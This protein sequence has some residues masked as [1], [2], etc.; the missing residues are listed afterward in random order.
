MR[1]S[2]AT[3]VATALSACLF[4]SGCGSTTHSVRTVTVTQT[5]TSTAT[6]TVTKPPP[7]TVTIPPKRPAAHS[8]SYT[9]FEGAYFTV[10]YPDTWTVVTSEESKSDYLD[11]TIQSDTDLNVILRV[12]VSP[13]SG[14]T[15][16]LTA[17]DTVRS[18]L[19]S[20]PRYREFA[21]DRV[22]YQG[23]GAAWAFEVEQQGVL[24]RKLDT[25]F[26]SADGDS[27]A[28]LVQAPASNYRRWTR[29]FRH[30]RSS[31]TP[32]TYANDNSGQQH[33][34][35]APPP[36]ASEADFCTTHAC[37]E[38]FYE[39]TGYIV[40]CADGMWSHSGGNSGACSYHGGETSNTYP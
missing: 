24:L 35:V 23:D 21:F 18:Y 30:I 39:G 10:D 16:P 2:L 40:Q 14:E 3:A 32:V 7:L 27:F 12:D 36:P 13:Q 31:L 19:V 25:F 26:I 11:T 8:A 29:I 15:D 22:A 20:Q 17:A 4:A 6:T 9:T 38:S 34:Q 37:I 5:R 1:R 33:V 28:I